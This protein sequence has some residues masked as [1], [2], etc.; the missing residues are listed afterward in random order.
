MKS[1]PLIHP[2]P[3]ARWQRWNRPLASVETS[4]E[5]RVNLFWVWRR[6][7]LCIMHGCLLSCMMG[8][9]HT[10]TRHSH[11][12]SMGWLK[13]QYWFNQQLLSGLEQTGGTHRA[14]RICLMLF[15]HLFSS[16]C[17]C[18]SHCDPLEKVVRP[19]CPSNSFRIHD[20]D[21]CLFFLSGEEKKNGGMGEWWLTREAVIYIGE[22]WTRGQKRKKRKKNSAGKVAEDCSHSRP[23][24]LR[25]AWLVEHLRHIGQ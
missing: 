8:H 7:N 24:G 5:T 9:T 16:T 17:V 4:R 10:H 20:P 11:L 12:D 18:C 22:D 14:L 1:D 6:S 23:C 3:P 2:D 25:A 21:S 19:L 13:L 15:A